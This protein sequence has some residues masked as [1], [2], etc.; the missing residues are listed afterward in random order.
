MPDPLNFFPAE[1]S[2]PA[3]LHFGQVRVEIV[4]NRALN[5]RLSQCLLPLKLQLEARGLK[6]QCHKN[7]EPETEGSR[8]R[9]QQHKG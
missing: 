1:L 3:K 9:P 7:G 2:D 4:G 5:Q 8:W 6:T